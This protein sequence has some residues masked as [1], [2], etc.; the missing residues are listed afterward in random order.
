MILQLTKLAEPLKELL[1]NDTLWYWETKHHSTFEAIK[2][3]L[4]KTLVLAYFDPK[5]D[6]IIQV[7]W[8]MKGLVIVLLQKGGPVIQE[9]RTLTPA[10]TH[11]S[12]IEWE[13]LSVVFGLERLHHYVFDSKIKVH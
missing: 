11:H 12:N 4:N 6:Y 9:S 1:R 10:E 8:S 5:T 3:E 7:D 2:D 13:L